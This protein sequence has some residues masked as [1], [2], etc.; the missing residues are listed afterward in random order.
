MLLLIPGQ[1]APGWAIVA[2]ETDAYARW[3]QPTF[4]VAS[5]SHPPEVHQFVLRRP[6]YVCPLSPAIVKEA[7]TANQSCGSSK[8]VE[9]GFLVRLPSAGK[10]LLQVA[11][12]TDAFQLEKVTICEIGLMT[13][14]L[15]SVW[16]YI[17]PLLFHPHLSWWFLREVSMLVRSEDTIEKQ[18]RFCKERVYM[19]RR[20]GR[21]FRSD[22][23][24]NPNLTLDRGDF[25]LAFPPRIRKSWC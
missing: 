14:V 23:N 18:L 22:P 1:F 21:F 2:Y 16:R 17:R 13:A 8:R 7:P 25:T 11:P 19:R 6:L 15:L 4:S 10:I 9:V 3:F 20:W 5:E 12:L 24:Y